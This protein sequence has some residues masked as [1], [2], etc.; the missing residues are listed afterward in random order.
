[1]PIA[2]RSLLSVTGP[3]GQ[4]HY[5]AV[6]SEAMQYKTKKQRGIQM[7]SWTEE[8]HCVKGILSRDR[9]RLFTGT[10]RQHHHTLKETQ[11]LLF[12]HTGP[13]RRQ[14]SLKSSSWGRW[15]QTCDLVWVRVTCRGSPLGAKSRLC[16][17]SRSSTTRDES[18]SVDVQKN[19]FFQVVR[20]FDP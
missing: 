19:I 14:G 6:R 2:F 9:R 8:G 15:S 7:L 1:M 3:W 20:L 16:K 10:Q 18:C 5:T 4:R 12:S 13:G 17:M 11:T